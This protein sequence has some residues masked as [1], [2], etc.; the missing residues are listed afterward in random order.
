MEG[1]YGFPCQ[2]FKILCV[3]VKRCIQQLKYFVIYKQTK[4]IK[5]NIQTSL[6]HQFQQVFEYYN[7]CLERKK[8]KR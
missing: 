5:Q 7:E 1:M 3:H 2:Y 4:N 8:K 6:K